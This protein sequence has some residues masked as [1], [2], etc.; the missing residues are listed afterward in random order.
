MALCT[1]PN[2]TFQALKDWIANGNP[3]ESDD[4]FAPSFLMVAAEAGH[5]ECC[6][7][8][9]ESGANIYAVDYSTESSLHRAAMNGHSECVTYFL[10]IGLNDHG[11]DLYVSTALDL[12]ILRGYSRCAEILIDHGE[13]FNR[14]DILENYEG[15]YPYITD[16]SRAEV[17][18]SIDEA[19]AYSEVPIKSALD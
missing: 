4:R 6:K 10:S 5:L 1:D 15:Y 12:A 7:L 16:R 8:L 2:H 17:E 19:I 18:A 14:E 13:I 9:V 11:S 3:I